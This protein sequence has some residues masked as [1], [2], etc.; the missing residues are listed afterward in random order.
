MESI[1]N[2]NNINMEIALKKNKSMQKIKKIL[3]KFLSKLNRA[4]K[5]EKVEETVVEISEFE[6]EINDNLANELLERQLEE[7]KNKYREA[8]PVVVS[9]FGTFRWSAMFNQFIPVDQDLLDAKFCETSHQV[10]QIQC[11]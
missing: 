8:I 10:P 1:N 2:S 9:E 5:L 3:K 7:Q 11:C 6:N 4:K